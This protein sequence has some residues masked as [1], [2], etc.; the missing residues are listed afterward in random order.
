MDE[1]GF[2]GLGPVSTA[3]SGRNLSSPATQASRPRCSTQL[4][5]PLRGRKRSR[6]CS[7]RASV[8]NPTTGFAFL[9]E[10]RSCD[11]HSRPVGR[12][13]ASSS[14]EAVP[15]LEAIHDVRPSAL[16]STPTDRK[17]FHTTYRDIL[18]PFDTG[19]EFSKPQ[20]KMQPGMSQADLVFQ[21]GDLRYDIAI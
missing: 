8:A 11:S 6:P 5:G 1:N 21:N 18:G 7:G 10:P 16:A 15:L 14:P 13:I 19:T 12:S 3:L 2:V 9:E 20:L 4:F 17:W